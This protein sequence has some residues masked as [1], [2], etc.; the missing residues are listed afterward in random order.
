MKRAPAAYLALGAGLATVALTGAAFWLSYAH[1]HAVAD[2]HGLYGVRAWAWP[3]TVD[4]FIV[5]GELLMLRASLLGR[6]DPWAVALTAIGSLGSVALNV[7]GVGPGQ[8]ALAY[9]V[10]AV[11]PSAA[12]IAFGALLHQI[13]PVLAAV[14]GAPAVPEPGVPAPARVRPAPRVRTRSSRTRAVPA[15]PAA[16]TPGTPDPLTARVRTEYAEAPSVRELKA[17]YSIGQARAQRIRD[18]LATV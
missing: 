14:P 12:L 18:A 15:A 9:V 2:G 5:A 3:S 17:R 4:L 7:A 10:A 6:T 8:G 16:G 13:R 1:L 11:P